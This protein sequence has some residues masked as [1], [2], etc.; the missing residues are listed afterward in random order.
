MFGSKAE[1][2]LLKAPFS[3]IK[4]QCKYCICCPW[5][6]PENIPDVLCGRKD[7]NKDVMLK[8]CTLQEKELTEQ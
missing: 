7:V 8:K 5:K 4:K 6:I 2:L 3:I 1:C